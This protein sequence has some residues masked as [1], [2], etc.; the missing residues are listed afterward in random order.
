MV[1][2]LCSFPNELNC[3]KIG[4]PISKNSSLIEF[5]PILDAEGRLQ[6]SKFSLNEKH[7]ILLP[8]KGKL[9]ELLVRNAHERVFPFGI[10][11]TG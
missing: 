4:E 10:N 1:L 8:S 11:D 7:P 2:N 5:S 9:V 6:K 3:L